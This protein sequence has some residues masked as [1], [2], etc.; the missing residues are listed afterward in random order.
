MPQQPQQQLDPQAVALAKAIRETESKSDFNAKGK[1]GEWGAYQWTPATWD[2]HAREAGV[3]AVFGS[4]TPDQQNEVAY[5]KIKQWKDQGYNP[6]QIA[7]MWNAGVGKPNAYVEGNKGVNSY[8][9]Q[10]DTKK[11]AEDVAR[12]YQR[13]KNQPAKTNAPTTQAIG[14]QS[15]NDVSLIE[16]LGN[17]AS[18][19][20]GK[21]ANA[22]GDIFRGKEDPKDIGV[23]SG[24]I[25]VLGGLGGG[26]AGAVD[27]VLEHTPVVKDV[28]GGVKDVAGKFVEGIAETEP[29]QD[30]IKAYGEFAQKHPELAGDISAG[31]EALNL[32]PAYK[33]FSFT[34]NKISGGID[35]VLH[36][37]T[38]D[39]LETIKPNMT[40]T[41]TKE[42]L[43][44]N[45]VEKKGLLRTVRLKEDPYD[46]AIANT[47]KKNVPDF[48]TGKPLLY[49]INAV[50]TTVRDMAT[51]LKQRVHAEGE[52]RIFSF[53]EFASALN[54]IDRPLLISS[55]V[56]L[57]NAYNRVIAKALEI[58]KK[59]GG[60]VPNLLDSRQEFDAFIKK[61]FPNLWKSDTLTPMRQAVKDIRNA[62]T[63]FTVKNLPENTGLRESY[64]I[65]TRL[66][67]AMENMADKASKGI[68][69]EVG[70]T[71]LERYGNRHPI[72]KGLAKRSLDV[73]TSAL[74][75]GGAIKL[76][77]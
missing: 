8:G 76:T 64:L 1:S 58:V 46:V 47:V 5:K 35:T 44:N 30:A 70:T 3:N 60:K 23:T 71:A 39:V 21:V 13:L 41:R 34:K 20:G 18:E 49:N 45:G 22:I 51:K 14:E 33:G 68:T 42:A 74:G 11:Y 53:K 10:Y 32:I 25:R 52:G 63:D 66:L 29:A 48:D 2:A 62:M 38:D 9:V 17:T 12:A 69:K 73:G 77:D 16:A 57:N 7:S 54:S 19:A 55:D 24:L 15:G 43:L 27:D 56:T 75:L 67:T 28:Y 61:Q 31:L 40:P 6:G 59:K 36:G 37:K 4:A 50:Q 65:Q 26:V 72:Q